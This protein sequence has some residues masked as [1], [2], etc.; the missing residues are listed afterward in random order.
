[1]MNKRTC[2]YICSIT[3]MAIAAP[4]ARAAPQNGMG[5]YVGVIGA[6]ED[7]V[8]SNGLSAG[9]DAQ[10]MLNDV[11][12][13]APYLML[14]AERDANSNTIADGLAGLPLRRWY[15]DWFAGVQAFE[16]DR[17]VI[18]NGTVQSSAYGLSGGVVAG[19]EYANG[20]GAEAQ[21]DLYESTNT[22]GAKRNAL[23]LH[24]TY[25]WH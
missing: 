12:S 19:F 22:V 3:I 8:S 1:M 23:R 9:V 17:I 2:L 13:V 18:N 25:R 11:W 5:V 16:H 7:G 24:L 14:S 6:T 4:A 20:W 10:F 21:A 15:G